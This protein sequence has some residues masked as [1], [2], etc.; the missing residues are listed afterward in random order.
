[1]SIEKQVA[2]Q[3]LAIKAVFLKPNE[4]F[5]WA[6]GIKSPIYCDNRLTLG[7]PKVRQFIAQSLAEKI[8]QTFGEVDVVAGTATAGIPH[9]AWVSDLLDLP[10]VYVRSKAKEH[11]KGNQIEGPIAKGQKVVVIEDLISTGGSSLKAVEAL[12]EAGAEVVG[13]AA[14]F[15][16]GLDKGKKLLEEADTKLVT[17][18]NYDELI[19]VALKEKYVTSEDM[20]T[21]KEWKKN[22]EIWGK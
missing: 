9:A 2:E 19:E 21:L 5:T 16:Y 22:P 8:K 4:P 11:G 14:I 3:L 18:T 6:S 20:A 12:E 15:T 17:L 10:M 13:I 1:M 7:F